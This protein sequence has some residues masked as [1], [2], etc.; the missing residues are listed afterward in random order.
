[1]IMVSIMVSILV[2]NP[3]FDDPGFDV[4]VRVVIEGR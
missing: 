3:G 1:L 4:A 2:L